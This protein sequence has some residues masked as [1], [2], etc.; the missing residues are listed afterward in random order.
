MPNQEL[1][2][3]KKTKNK[4]KREWK[5]EIGEEKQKSNLIEGIKSLLLLCN[6]GL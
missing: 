1:W 5:K 2:D 6:S 3:Q 4:E